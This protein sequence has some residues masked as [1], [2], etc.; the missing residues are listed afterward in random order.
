MQ[1]RKIRW[2]LW[3]PFLL[4][5]VVSITTATIDGKLVPQ[6]KFV[7]TSE[8]SLSSLENLRRRYAE[9]NSVH[10]VADAKIVLYGVNFAVG[11]GSFEYWEQDKQY[12]YKCRTDRSLKLATDVDVAYNGERFQFLDLRSGTL[13]YRSSDDFRSIAALPNPLFLPVEYLSKEDDDCGLCRLRLSELKSENERWASRARALELKVRQY[14]SNGVITD[15]EMPGGTIQKHLFKIRLRMK[16][17]AEENTWPSEIDKIDQDGHV[18]ASVVFNNFMD[19]SMLPVPRDTSITVFD[20]KGNLA[21][22]LEYTVKLLEINQRLQ[23]DVFNIS[24]DDAESVWD[25]DGKKFVKEKRS[26]APGQ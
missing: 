14:D 1:S 20:D 8:K 16:G 9:V 24:F 15:L 4:L 2:K 10:L 18:L 23:N 26:K 22:R 7:L 6:K 5:A 17:K 25:S 21:L 11:L 19:N 3:A 12:R 13:S